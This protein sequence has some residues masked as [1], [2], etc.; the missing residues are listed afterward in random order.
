M[1]ES[2]WHLCREGEGEGEREG[3]GEGEGDRKIRKN[4]YSG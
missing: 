4:F 3:E 2:S 1:K